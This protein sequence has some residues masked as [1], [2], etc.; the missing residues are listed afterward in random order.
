VKQKSA[1][2]QMPRT[3]S[4][5]NRRDALKVLGAGTAALMLPRA[6]AA[7]GRDADVIVI[8]AGLA[9]LQ[10]AI[11]LQD[12][13]L[14]VLVVEGNDRVGGRVWSL[15]KAPGQPEA[16]GAEIAPGYARMHAMIAR[17]GNIQLASWMQYQSNRS[18]AIYDGDK[19][20]TLDDW[21]K[22]PANRFSAAEQ[23]RIGPPGPFGVALSYLPQPNPLPA[24]D[25]WLDK[26]SAALD[27]PLDQYLR[28]L[29]ASA[30]ALRFAASSVPAD[31]VS[32]TSALALLRMMRVYDEMGP[33]DGLQIFA[34]G[35]SRVPE[36][37][38]A[39]LKR[40]VRF[41]SKVTGLRTQRGGVEIAL[42]DGSTLRA[43]HAVCSVPLPVLRSLRIDPALPPLQAEAVQR[44]PY[45]SAL[46]IFFAIKEPFWETDGL[47]PTTRGC[48]DFGRA[49]VRRSPRGEHIWFHKS[50]ASA[51]PYKALPDAELMRVATKE[52]NKARPSTIG[53]VEASQ[54]VNWNAI[55]WNRAHLHHRGPGD[56]TKFGNIAA[57]AHGRIHFAGEHTSVTMMGMEGAMES[58]ERAAIEILLQL[59]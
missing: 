14:D 12:E 49:S 47:P 25:S 10:A 48:D 51:L 53:R 11:L 55:P 1:T 7:G 34:Q 54:V 59:G 28:G 36:G 26:E 56:I 24:L 30:E 33:Y 29:G 18:F 58:G 20:S 9:G 31:S 41:G 43:G 27:V 16:G 8:G 50:G 44:V 23:A 6:V 15:D 2:R 38:A 22:S 32:A 39:L 42:A 52:L 37:M 4:A 13:G 21:R 3:A 35:T 19:L 57:E 46:S 17:L 40:G 45:D 5:W